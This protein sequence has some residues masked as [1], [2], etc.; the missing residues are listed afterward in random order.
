MLTNIQTWVNTCIIRQQDK[1]TTAKNTLMYPIATG[2]VFEA[3]HCEVV[4]PFPR[5]NV[6]SRYVAPRSTIERLTAWPEV[7]AVSQADS[8]VIA[9]LILHH[10]IF[11]FR[12]PMHFV[13]DQGKNF[14]SNLMAEVCGMLKI[15]QIKNTPYHPQSNGIV[16]RLDGMLVKGISHFADTK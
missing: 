14:L 6:G 7:F 9:E 13:T 15:K 3:L 4:R 16:E 8:S 2:E 12:I 5:T 10:I 1:G 11:R